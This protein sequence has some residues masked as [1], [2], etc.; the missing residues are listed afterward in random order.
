MIRIAISEATFKAIALTM[1]LGFVG[2][3]AE[4]GANGER[5]IWL[6]AAVVDR[7]RELGGPQLFSDSIANPVFS[8]G[9][10]SLT[11]SESDAGVIT[12]SVVPEPSTWAMMLL[13]FAGLA[14][15]GYRTSRRAVSIAD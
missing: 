8:V 6:P 9:S 5:L 15:A 13:A 1:P 10:F 11:N 3:E 14:F 4:A 12:F 7:L 2:Y